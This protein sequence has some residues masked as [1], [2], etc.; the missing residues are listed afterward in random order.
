MK[1][2]NLWVILIYHL[3]ISFRA[4]M[5][6]QRWQMALL[7]FLLPSSLSPPSPLP[8]D[9][10]VWHLQPEFLLPDWVDRIFPLFVFNFSAA[11]LFF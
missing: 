7:G 10:Y 9:F 6:A 8:I 5:K 4:N 2:R 1:R 11:N 3:H